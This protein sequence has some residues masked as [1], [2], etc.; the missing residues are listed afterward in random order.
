MWSDSQASS[1]GSDSV[2]HHVLHLV[3]R[4]RAK[5]SLRAG[6]GRGGDLR[7]LLRVRERRRQYVV[8]VDEGV[9]DVEIGGLVGSDQDRAQYQ[10]TGSRGAELGPAH[11][12]GAGGER[13]GG[14]ALGQTQAPSAACHHAEVAAE[15]EAQAPGDGVSGRLT[16][17][18]FKQKVLEY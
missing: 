2:L 3:E 8:R 1:S 5:R 15:R 4:G 14:L 18:Q 16:M 6:V 11:A 10:A 7:E 17:G 12:Q 13:H 9:D